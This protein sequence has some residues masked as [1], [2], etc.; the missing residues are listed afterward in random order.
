M[1]SNDPR[2]SRRFSFSISSQEGSQIFFDRQL[3]AAVGDMANVSVRSD[4]ERDIVLVAD[5]VSRA[6]VP[7]VVD[8]LTVAVAVHR[9]DRDDAHEIVVT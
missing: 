9:Q 8:N 3:P 2:R 7:V 6:D 4:E 5:A 1:S